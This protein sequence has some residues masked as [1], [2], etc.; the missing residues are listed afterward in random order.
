MVLA[1]DDVYQPLRHNDNLDDLVP[2]NQAAN[3][4]VVESRS[5]QFFLGDIR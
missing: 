5:A 1:H 3:L 4:L 2:I